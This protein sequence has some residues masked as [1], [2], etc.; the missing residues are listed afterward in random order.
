MYKRGRGQ[1]WREKAGG[2]LLLREESAAADSPSVAVGWGGATSGCLC[3]P[4]GRSACTNKPTPG[5]WSNGNQT[6]PRTKSPSCSFPP[7]LLPP[8]HTHTHTPQLKDA[9]QLFQT[10]LKIFPVPHVFSH[11]ATPRD[12]LRSALT[13]LTHKQP[14]SSDRRLSLFLSL[15]DAFAITPPL[16]LPPFMAGFP[17]PRFGVSRRKIA[18]ETFAFT[19][20]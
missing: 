2:G 4:L 8:T 20:T 11:T 17:S 19:L 16:S 3:S 6:C 15:I 9:L 7:L 14:D 5:L 12:I 10:D 13:F 1:E 18:T